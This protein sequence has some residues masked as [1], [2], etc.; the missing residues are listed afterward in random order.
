MRSQLRM[1]L[2]LF[3]LILFSSCTSKTPQ[4]SVPPTFF[5]YRFN[6][7]AFVEFS[8]DF[9]SIKEIPFE[10]P[11]NCGLL[12]TFPA[13]IGKYI[14]IELNCPN[15]QTILFLDTE[16]G[17]TTQPVTDSDS[18]FLAWARDGKAAYLKVDSLGKAH[19]ARVDAEGKNDFIPITELTYD[20]AAD[21]SKDDFIFTFSRG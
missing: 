14:L 5:V 13:P 15:G 11:L 19:V 12:N 7:S 4:P 21:P 16:L 8:Q 18:H 9:Q 6:P 3:L 2:C 10:V 20:L 17:T 1:T